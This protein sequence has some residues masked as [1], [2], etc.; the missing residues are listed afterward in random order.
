M[1]FTVF[2]ITSNIHDFSEDEFLYSGVHGMY[3]IED[4]KDKGY[5]LESIFSFEDCMKLE[6]QRSEKKWEKVFLEEIIFSSNLQFDPSKGWVYV[7]SGKE[8]GDYLSICD[9]YQY[10]TPKDSN[11]DNTRNDLFL[12][13]IDI[14]CWLENLDSMNIDVI[15]ED[16]IFT[17]DIPC[18]ENLEKLRE[19][20]AQIDHEKFRIY[21]LDVHS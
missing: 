2:L 10:I 17:M 7:T 9:K 5:Q 1:H 3:D 16:E 8:I 13:E 15:V 20:L 12:N 4:A 11:K 6:I 18:S 21:E 14:E 19:R